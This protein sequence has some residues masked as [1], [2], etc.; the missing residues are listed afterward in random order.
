MICVGEIVNTHGIKGEVKVSSNFQLK[1]DIFKNDVVI[2]VGET[3]E[4]LKIIR[5]RKHKNFD[6]LTF[7][8]HSNINDVLAF[9]GEFVYVLKEELPQDKILH[10]D[11]IGYRVVCKGEDIGLVKDLFNNNAHDILV[12]KK[13]EKKYLIPC[14]NSF[15]EK[16][17]IDSKTIKISQTEGYICEN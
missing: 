14:V 5:H 2:Y 11:L 6:M 9:K 10:C 16:I 3:K 13:E 15:F 8:N 12:V 17:D 7:D 4:K 1:E